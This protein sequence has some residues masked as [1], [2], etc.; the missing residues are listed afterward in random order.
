M[1]RPYPSARTRLSHHMQDTAKA[2]KGFMGFGGGSDPAPVQPSAP[3]SDNV[4]MPSRPSSGGGTGLS[5][6]SLADPNDYIAAHF[7][8]KV[9]EESARQ[10][11]P[12]DSWRW[13]KRFFIFSGKDGSR[14]SAL[15]Y[16]DF[17]NRRCC[18]CC[19]FWLQGAQWVQLVCLRPPLDPPVSSASTSVLCCRA[20]HV[21]VQTR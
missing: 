6:G 16:P 8:K 3:S 17:S 18:L 21:P 20:V 15:E 11:L 7:D 9:N 1:R 19:V 12:V 2:K 4:L 13:Q 14:T 5:L 10:S